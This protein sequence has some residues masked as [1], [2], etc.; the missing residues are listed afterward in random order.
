MPSAKPDGKSDT[1]VAVERIKTGVKLAAIGG[2]SVVSIA[3]KAVSVGATTVKKT[4]NKAR[5][6][7]LK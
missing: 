6:D 3:A 5:S 1:E 2:L 4:A 7:L